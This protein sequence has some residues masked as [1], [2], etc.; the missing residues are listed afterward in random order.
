[1]NKGNIMIIRFSKTYNFQ[2]SEE[3]EGT[4]ENS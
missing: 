3:G 4:A 2:I 1:V